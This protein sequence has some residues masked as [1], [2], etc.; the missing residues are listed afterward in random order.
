[1]P[2]LI[3]PFNL[4][5]AGPLDQFYRDCLRFGNLKVIATKREVV[6]STLE[7]RLAVL[8]GDLA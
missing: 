8:R 4:M 3:I 2:G 6:C 7:G 5:H 1:M